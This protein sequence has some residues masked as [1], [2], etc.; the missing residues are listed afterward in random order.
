MVDKENK[1]FPGEIR[2]GTEHSDPRVLHGAKHVDVD[3]FSEPH[4]AQA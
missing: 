3:Y 4:E 1:G 2:V